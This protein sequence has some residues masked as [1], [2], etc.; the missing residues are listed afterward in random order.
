LIDDAVAKGATKIEVAGA[1]EAL[2][3]RAGRRIAP[4][5]LL[6]VT[7][8]MRIDSN[9]VFGPVLSVHAYDRVDDVIARLSERPSPLAAYWYGPTGPEFERFRSRTRSGGMTVDDFALHCGMMTAPFG[10]VGRSGYGAYH[11]KA[12]FDTFTHQRTIVHN[13]TPV[14]IATMIVPST[15]PR[16]EKALSV[17][18]DVVRRRSDRRRRKAH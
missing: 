9:E 8:E 14:S 12:G 7:A 13:K 4:T 18:V 11:G 6:N 15:N 2:P 10:G 1:G 17:V 16:V 3:D 5:L